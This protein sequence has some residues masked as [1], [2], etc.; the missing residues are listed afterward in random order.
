MSLIDDE[1]IFWN[2]LISEVIST[3]KIDNLSG[4]TS[5]LWSLGGDTKLKSVD[6]SNI[7]VEHIESI[8]LV[9]FIN[10]VG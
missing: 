3:K 7:G 10:K 5:L 9:L 2:L 8:P 6:S 1:S 4:T